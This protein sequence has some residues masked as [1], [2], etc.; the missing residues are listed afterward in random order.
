MKGRT[1]FI[2]IVLISLI[3]F[4]V[5]MPA[6]VYHIPISKSQI[7][8]A[9]IKYEMVDL[10]F[11]NAVRNYLEYRTGNVRIFLNNDEIKSLYV[12]TNDCKKLWP[13]SPFAMKEKNYTIIATFKVS[14]ALFGNYTLAR[15]IDTIHVSDSPFIHK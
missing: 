1:K 7:F 10:G 8:K 9:E 12:D 5:W 11:D 3:A 6:I 2:L 15:V 13:E 4:L 14:K